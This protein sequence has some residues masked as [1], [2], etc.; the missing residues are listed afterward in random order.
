MD[1][2]PFK[3]VTKLAFLFNLKNKF[4]NRQKKSCTNFFWLLQPTNNLKINQK[5]LIYQKK[6][7]TKK[8][9]QKLF[10][11]TNSYGLFAFSIK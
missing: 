5:F 2:K 3:K 8:L 4:F 11:Q 1:K 9:N 7:S 10:Y 6:K